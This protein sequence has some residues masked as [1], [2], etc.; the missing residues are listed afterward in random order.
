MEIIGLFEGDF[1]DTWGE[2]FPLVY[3]GPP[4]ARAEFATNNSY[5]YA[6]STI[7]I[8]WLIWYEMHLVQGL[9]V[10]QFQFSISHCQLKYTFSNLF[11]IL[12]LLTISFNFEI[13]IKHA[14]AEG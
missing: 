5:I 12:L 2:K 3:V 6:P 9:N 1:A 8:F 4:S 10:K 13:E 14:G 7:W 11:L